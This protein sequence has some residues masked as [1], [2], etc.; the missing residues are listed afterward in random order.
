MDTAFSSWRSKCG[1]FF[2]AKKQLRTDGVFA[3]RAAFSSGRR[4]I[5]SSREVLTRF[6]WETGIHKDWRNVQRKTGERQLEHKLAEWI[7]AKFSPF[8]WAKLWIQWIGIWLREERILPSINSRNIKIRLQFCTT[9]CGVRRSSLEIIFM[10]LWISF[11][12]KYFKYQFSHSICAGKYQIY[13]IS[14][15]ATKFPL[16]CIVWPRKSNCRITKL[17]VSILHLPDF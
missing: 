12:R 5:R 2:F 15:K 9:K 16:N 1:G 17:K 8:Y 6:N 14:L 10:W 13:R 7:Y 4:N 3:D 11:T